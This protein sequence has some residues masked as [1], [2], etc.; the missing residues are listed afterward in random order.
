MVSAKNKLGWTGSENRSSARHY[1]TAANNTP[2]SLHL[3]LAVMLFPQ[4]N[5]QA[6]LTEDSVAGQLL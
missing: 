3:S 5:P 6:E 2:D 4:G 1:S